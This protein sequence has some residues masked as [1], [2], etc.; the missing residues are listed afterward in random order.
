MGSG[1]VVLHLVRTVNYQR[2][3]LLRVLLRFIPFPILDRTRG[4]DP[5]VV[6][7]LGHLY[8]SSLLGSGR[9]G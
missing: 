4:T 9:R 6:P 5:G 2:H 3:E 7:S 8:C 1:E